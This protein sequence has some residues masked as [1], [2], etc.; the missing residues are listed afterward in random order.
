MTRHCCVLIVAFGFVYLVLR[1]PNVDHLSS[2]HHSDWCALFVTFELCAS[3]K[4]HTYSRVGG[5]EMTYYCQSSHELTYNFTRN[6]HKR[7]INLRGLVIDEELEEVEWAKSAIVL[8]RSDDWLSSPSYPTAFAY[9]SPVYR[10][11]WNTTGK[12]TYPTTI[13]R[14]IYNFSQLCLN[15]PTILGFVWVSLGWFILN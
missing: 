7:H 11:F 4:S 5:I 9:K 1:L 2:M 13:F 3:R 15:V 10:Q 8:T 12:R 6:S 14:D